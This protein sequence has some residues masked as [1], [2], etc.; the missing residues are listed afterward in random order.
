MDYVRVWRKKDGFLEKNIE[1]KKNQHTE[2]VVDNEGNG[3]IKT[4]I[5]SLRVVIIKND[6]TSKK[7]KNKQ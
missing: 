4:K 5:K 7:E 1:N 3:D 6:M 2:N